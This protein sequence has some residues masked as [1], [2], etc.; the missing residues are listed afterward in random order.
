MLQILEHTSSSYGPRTYVNAKSAELTVAFAADFTTAGERLTHKAA[1]DRYL[2]IPLEEDP[3]QAARVLYKALRDGGAH[4]L[5][6]A[7]NGIYTLARHGWT[8]ERVNA[9]LYAVLAKVHEHWPLHHVRSGGQT[10][11]DLAG[12]VAAY[13]LGIDAEALLPKGFVQR[14]TDK[15][16]RAVG[17]AGV[18]AQVESGAAVLAPPPAPTVPE[19]LTRVPAPAPA[20]APATAAAVAPA[21]LPELGNIRVVSK[22]KGGTKPTRAESVIDGD[23][24]NPVYGNRHYLTDWQDPEERDRVIDKHLTED[25]EPDVLSR[26]PIYQAMTKHADRLRQGEDLAISCWCAPYRCHCDHIASGIQSLAQGAD[27]QAEVRAQ[28]AARPHAVPVAGASAAADALPRQRK[29]F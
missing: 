15:V 28:I 20:T 18:R 12:V 22:R 23:R 9:Y 26:G 21:A 7:G 4:T 2:S 8:Q 27:L 17:E 3:L 6:V 25:F 10:G 19:P 14:G 13:A 16:D 1:G 24:A 11:V 5:N 29:L